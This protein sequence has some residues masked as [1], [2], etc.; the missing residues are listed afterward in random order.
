V[1]RKK[2][3][4][5]VLRAQAGDR[6]ALGSL[7]KSIQGPLYGYIRKMLCDEALAEDVLQEVMITVCQKI[8]ALRSPEFFQ[9][10]V[11][12]IASRQVFKESRRASRWRDRFGIDSVTV[13]CDC[14]SGPIKELDSLEVEE[15]FASLDRLS[16]PVRSV[17][18]LH[19][20]QEMT[21]NEVATVLGIAVGTVKSRLA[22]GL[23]TLRKQWKSSD[24]RNQE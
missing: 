4:Y 18:I 20:Q 5:W 13:D 23:S 24:P 7:L 9:A 1:D 6:W 12:R 15:L 2:K 19:Y 8:K 22:F 17:L 21:L 3:I 14:V 10:W 11:Y 16:P